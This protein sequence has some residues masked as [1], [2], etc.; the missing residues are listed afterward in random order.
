MPIHVEPEQEACTK[1]R[2]EVSSSQ[3]CSIALRQSQ[4]K[5]RL[6]F[7]SAGVPAHAGYYT[8]VMKPSEIPRSQSSYEKAKNLYYK[9]KLGLCPFQS[10]GW[11]SEPQAELRQCSEEVK[12]GGLGE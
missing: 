4:T 1:N 11:I 6:Q 10:S 3:L 5:W 2:S 9:L 7:G 12:D 8:Q